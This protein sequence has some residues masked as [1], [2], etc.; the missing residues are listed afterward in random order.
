M[1]EDGFAACPLIMAFVRTGYEKNFLYDQSSDFHLLLSKLNTT[2]E[3]LPNCHCA[4][5]FW[6]LYA[7][8]RALY[9]GA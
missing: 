3:V 5:D 7:K 2:V 1:E 8:C 9:L 6:V 4:E